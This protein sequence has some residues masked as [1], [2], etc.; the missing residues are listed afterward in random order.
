MLGIVDTSGKLIRKEALIFDEAPI[1]SPL[2]EAKELGIT[3]WEYWIFVMPVVTKLKDGTPFTIDGIM[4][5]RKLS[6]EQKVEEPK[7]Q[8]RSFDREDA[9]KYLTKLEL[10][11]YDQAAKIGNKK[12][13]QTLN[14]KVKKAKTMAQQNSTST[15]TSSAESASENEAPVNKVED[16]FADDAGEVAVSVTENKDQTT[17]LGDAIE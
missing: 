9:A 17:V 13:L 12:Q 3:S 14:E 8:A 5:S 2:K 10:A 15:N 16:Q 11:A 7:P 6:G 1:A 4:Y